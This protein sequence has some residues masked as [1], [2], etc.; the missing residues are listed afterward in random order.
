MKNNSEQL[1]KAVTEFL[2]FAGLSSLKISVS[3][4]AHSFEREYLVG[5]DM[6]LPYT[7]DIEASV[8]PLIK[9]GEDIRNSAMI[10]SAV[11]DPL[12]KRI[13]EL[14]KKCSELEK[15]QPFKEHYEIEMKLRHGEK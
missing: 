7:N 6:K 8:T 9:L 14:E 12:E 1:E 11:T 4:T 3:L 13:L 15:L 2:S 10:R 5:L